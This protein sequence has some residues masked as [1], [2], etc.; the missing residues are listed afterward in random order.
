VYPPFPFWNYGTIDNQPWSTIV[1]NGVINNSFLGT[2]NNS[3]IINNTGTIDNEYKGTINNSHII[4]NSGTINNSGIINSSLGTFNNQGT[5]KGTGTFIGTLDTGTGTVAPGNSA[6]TMYV[7]GDYIL[8][9]T[10]ILDIEIGG[11]TAGLFDLLNITG[12]SDLPGGNINFSFL[13]GYDIISDIG[14]NQ[15]N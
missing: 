6:G 12:T 2:I 14:P 7:D 13:S 3:Y 9:G 11:F 1:N 15:S 10:G 5:L 8:A 4:N